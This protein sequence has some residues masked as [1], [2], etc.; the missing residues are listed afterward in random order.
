MVTGLVMDTLTAFYH[1][2][3]V[4]AAS[5]RAKAAGF[6]VCVELDG[7]QQL[8][9]EYRAGRITFKVQNGLVIDARIG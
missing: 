7:M 4:E 8:N 2:M 9:C 5:N 3:T 1:G 6:Q